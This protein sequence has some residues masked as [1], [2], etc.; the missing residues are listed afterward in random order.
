MYITFK[1][2]NF[3]EAGDKSV[4]DIV[5]ENDLSFIPPYPPYL[6]LSVPN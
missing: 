2:S 3:E 5:L 1:M 4:D 6:E